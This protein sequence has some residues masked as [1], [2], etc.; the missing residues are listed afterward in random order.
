MAIANGVF[1]PTRLD[2]WR[3]LVAE[4]AYN[5]ASPAERRALDRLAAAAARR[6]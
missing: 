1:T 3:A 5:S 4:E 6:K 2:R